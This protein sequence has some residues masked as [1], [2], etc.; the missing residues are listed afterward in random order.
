[1]LCVTR[2]PL[3]TLVDP[4]SMPTGTETSTAFLHAPSTLTRLDSI[5]NVVATRCSCSRA[6]SNGFSRRCD[7]GASTA[8][9]ACSFASEN[10][11]AECTPSLQSEGQLAATRLA[12]VHGERDDAD[13]VRA[14][15]QQLSVRAAAGEPERVATR[16][17]VAEARKRADLGPVAPPE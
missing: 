11:R 8:V 12:D 1:M 9:T 7:A 5:P 6:M 17:H 16:K 15:R 3:K 4:S 10:C 13:L 2:K 14:G